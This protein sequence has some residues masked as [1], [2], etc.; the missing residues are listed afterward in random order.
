M[1]CYGSLTLHMYMYM[2]D[3]VVDM[4]K[5]V[6]C[7]IQ[8]VRNLLLYYCSNHVNVVGDTSYRLN[9]FHC[10]MYISPCMHNQIS[11]WACFMINC[12]NPLL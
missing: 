3:V 12:L 4:H 5:S 1:C 11:T 10:I 6:Q 2:Y 7:M 9:V 8:L